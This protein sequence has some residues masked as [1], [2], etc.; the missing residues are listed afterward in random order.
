MDLIDSGRN[1]C[2]D[3]SLEEHRVG[4]SGHVL[5]T[6]TD[7]RP[8]ENGGRRRTIT[9]DIVGLLGDLFDQFGANFLERVL[10]LDLFGDRHTVVRNGGCAPLL[11]ENDVAALGPKRDAYCV[12]QLI[13]ASL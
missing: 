8:R 10:Q 12:G 4:A 7:H 1:S 3:A 11:F 2:L 13:H 9:G 6:V 5:Q